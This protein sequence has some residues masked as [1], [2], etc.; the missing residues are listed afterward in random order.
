MCIAI[1]IALIAL[2]VYYSDFVIGQYGLAS[3]AGAHSTPMVVAVGWEMIAPL[4]P[5]FALAMVIGITVATLIPRRGRTCASGSC[6][7]TPA[8]PQNNP[9]SE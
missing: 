4:W 8:R 9:R 7:T 1:Y 5:L 6:A 3:I 2:L